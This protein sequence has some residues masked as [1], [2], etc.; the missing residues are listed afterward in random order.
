MEE[1]FTDGEEIAFFTL[2]EIGRL[3]ALVRGLLEEPQRLERMA[4]AGC[5]KTQ[6]EHIWEERAKRIVEIAAS[7]C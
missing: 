4:A 5:E 7:V 6:R 2:T 1:K 3:P